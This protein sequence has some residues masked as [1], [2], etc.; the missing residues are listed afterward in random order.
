MYCQ[1]KQIDEAI[2]EYPSIVNLNPR[3]SVQTVNITKTQFSRIGLVF[4]IANHKKF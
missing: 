4:C 2:A 3:G 1:S